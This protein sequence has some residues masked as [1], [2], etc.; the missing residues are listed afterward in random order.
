VL[1]PRL[2][3]GFWIQNSLKSSSC[4]EN[5]DAS[6]RT[7]YLLPL[8]MWWKSISEQLT[9]VSI[10]CKG[11]LDNRWTYG[12]FR[13][14]TI[15]PPFR[16]WFWS[17]DRTAMDQ[18]HSL[19]SNDELTSWFVG[20][21]R[22]L[23]NRISTNNWFHRTNAKGAITSAGG[24]PTKRHRFKPS[25]SWVL[26]PLQNLICLARK[27]ANVIPSAYSQA[28]RVT[29]SEWRPRIYIIEIYFT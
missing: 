27:L 1:L 29:A 3:L 26:L 7:S 11:S 24:R 4:N 21:Y 10:N 25:A 12:T 15:A 9:P 18:S 14:N 5:G 16:T 28:A 23:T 13:D 8:S 20:R 2:L 22:N 19:L 17:L 6:H